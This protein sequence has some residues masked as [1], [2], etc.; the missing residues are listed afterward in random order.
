MATWAGGPQDYLCASQVSYFVRRNFSG[1]FEQGIH[2]DCSYLDVFTCNEPDECA[3]PAHPM[4]RSE[5]LNYRLSCFAWLNANGILPSS[6]EAADWSIPQ[7]VFCHYAPYSFMMQ[8]P[9]SARKG[10]P[11]PLYNLVYHDCLI[12][13]WPM[14]NHPDGEDYMLYALLNGGAAYIG[15]ILHILASTVHSLLPLETIQKK[16]CAGGGLYRNCSERSQ[17]WK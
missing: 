1:L 15:E 16:M 12:I 13:P 10:I 6:E 2:P 7:L 17:R 9:G 5:C 11:V 8:R 4:T 14:E 3:N